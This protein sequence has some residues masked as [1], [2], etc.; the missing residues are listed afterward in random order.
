LEDLTD[1]DKVFN[2]FERDKRS[3]IKKAAM[4]LKI[5]YDITPEDF[6]KVHKHGL[7]KRGMEINYSQ[8]LL[9]GIYQAAYG[10]GQ[11]KSIY[12]EDAQGNV[13]GCL[14]IIWDEKRANFLISAY[15]PE[16]RN[17]GLGSLLT[18][19]AIKYVSTRS[20]K[21]DFTGSV[22]ESYERSYRAF[23]GIQKPYFNIKK[24]YSPVYIIHDAVQQ[25]NY[26]MR[27][28]VKNIFSSG[29]R[30]KN[31][32]KTNRSPFRKSEAGASD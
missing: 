7:A 8:K 1:L 12:C 13:Q 20:E 11:G 29:T 22:V 32:G 27:L 5:G 21:C 25:L 3:W 6:Y 2:N 9:E 14:F 30:I 31:F 19:E 16:H 23:G 4:S 28:G 17:N 15:D 18:W 10:R 26:G 24:T